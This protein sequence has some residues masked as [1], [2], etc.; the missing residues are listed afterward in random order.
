MRLMEELGAASCRASHSFRDQM[1]AVLRVEIVEELVAARIKRADKDGN[2][3]A[4]PYHFFA[5]EI[6]AFEF[7]HGSVLI[8]NDQLDLLPGGHRYF[9]WRELAVLD[10]DHNPGVIS[11]DRCTERQKWEGD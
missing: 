8:A 4:G 9:T 2:L 6:A 11:L 10:R 7:G 5:M 1:T 3:S